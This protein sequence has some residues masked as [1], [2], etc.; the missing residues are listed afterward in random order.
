MSTQT[1]PSLLVVQEIKEEEFDDFLQEYLRANQEQE[2][3]PDVKH[4]GKAET[5]TA[6]VMT[7]KE[8]ESPLID[9][10]RPVQEEE[11]YDEELCPRSKFN[12][13]IF[14]GHEL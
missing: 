3:K 14:V 4:E 10:S 7:G 13:L 5:H 1:G 12:C 9:T 8:E 11:D 6:P 2:E